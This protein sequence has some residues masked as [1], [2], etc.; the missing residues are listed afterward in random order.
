MSGQ[1]WQK[2][3]KIYEQCLSEHKTETVGHVVAELKK[4]LR[5]LQSNCGLDDKKYGDY[6][7]ST[8]LLGEMYPLQS[9]DQTAQQSLFL[10]P[11]A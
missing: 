4:R 9:S 2:Y 7:T 3:R 8:V 6:I 11:L 5:E 1:N 10:P